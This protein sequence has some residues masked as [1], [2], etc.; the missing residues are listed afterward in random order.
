MGGLRPVHGAFAP[1]RRAR[2]W[3]CERVHRADLPSYLTRMRI[4]GAPEFEVHPASSGDELYPVNF[5]EPIGRNA[6][7]WAWTWRRRRS[8]AKRRNSRCWRT[9]RC[10]AGA[11][12]SCRTRKASRVSTALPIYE[13]GIHLET[14]EDRRRACRDGSSPRSASMNSCRDRRS[15]R[16][17]GGV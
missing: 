16:R 2:V 11:S 14:A 3:L 1:A 4:D 8:V 17:S 12:R 9:A 5:V 10:S 6:R 15:H 13:R 7:H